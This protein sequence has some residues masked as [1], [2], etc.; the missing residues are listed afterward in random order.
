[1][2]LAGRRTERGD[3]DFLIGRTKENLRE[4]KKQKEK[5]LTTDHTEHTAEK[6]KVFNIDYMI[7][8]G[9]TPMLCVMM[10]LSQSK[11]LHTSPVWPCA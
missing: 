6:E 3:P 7:K 5:I 11:K 2:S 4:L 8:G 9:E 1:M 10:I